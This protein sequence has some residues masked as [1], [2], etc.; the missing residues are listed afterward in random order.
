LVPKKKKE[1]EHDKGVGTLGAE[2]FERA[3]TGQGPT[4]HGGVK[5]AWQKPGGKRTKKSI[6]PTVKRRKTRTETYT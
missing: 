5:Q 1:R 4:C 6:G 3:K 2:S